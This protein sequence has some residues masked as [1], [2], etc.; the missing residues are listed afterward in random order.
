MQRRWLATLACVAFSGLSCNLFSPELGAL[1][2]VSAAPPGAEG[3]APSGE[4]EI[5]AISTALSRRPTGLT[6]R[7]VDAVARTVVGEARRH[8]LEPSL[9]MAVMH[10]ESRYYNFAVSPVG[11]IG[12]MQV[13]PETGEELAA[14]LGIDWVGPQT[15]FDPTVNVR[16]GVAYLRELSDRYGSLSTA[17]AAYNWG[18]GRID[19]RVRL[20]T[21]IPDQYPALVLEAYAQRRGRS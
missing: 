12:L 20:G 7:E 17:L 18:P 11:A 3:A 2:P 5:A 15:L 16:L 13:M 14:R 21:A 19:R 1:P 6:A 4:A 8:A 9:V 10:V